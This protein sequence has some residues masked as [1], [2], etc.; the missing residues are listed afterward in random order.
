M[1]SFLIDTISKLSHVLWITD[2]YSLFWEN[3][4]M[5]SLV[6]LVIIM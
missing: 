2:I 1:V 5:E 6:D 3:K 4:I